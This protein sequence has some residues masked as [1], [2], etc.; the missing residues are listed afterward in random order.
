M[1]KL[2]PQGLRCSEYI[3]AR[4]RASDTRRFPLGTAFFILILGIQLHLLLTGH[5]LLSFL[6]RSTHKNLST[7]DPVSTVACDMSPTRSKARK[8]SSL[9][10]TKQN[11][12]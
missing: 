10:A 5:E 12:A 1:R 2:N 3:A 11:P 9:L 6:F 7:L 4:G 8:Q